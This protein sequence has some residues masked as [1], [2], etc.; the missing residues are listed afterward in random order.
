MRRASIISAC[1]AALA[2]CAAAPAHG[3]AVQ[4]RAST[5]PRATLVACHFDVAQPSRF[6]VF[7]GSM[8][9]MRHGDDRMQMRFD[10][11][12][13]PPGSTRFARIQAPG[14]GVWNKASAGVLRYRFKQRVENLPAPGSYRAVVSFRWLSAQG[15]VFLRT[16]RTTP[17]CVQP[18][19]RPDLRAPRITALRLGAGE[20]R[21][22]VVVRNDGRSAASDFDVVLTVG[23]QAQPASTVIG[24]AAGA[25]RTVSF[26]APRCTAG[27]QV[28][29]DVDPDDRVAEA[30]ETNNTLTVDCP[31][32]P[33]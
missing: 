30:D 12:R 22:D 5:E 7:G 2:A 6:A 15:K 28:R 26:T 33:S 9:S 24:L 18:D 27:S 4:L 11:Y 16:K 17:S 3:D 13:R 21:Y 25:R 29:V 14:L 8:T 19:P 20:W 32:P 31:P 1:A 10:V 23:D